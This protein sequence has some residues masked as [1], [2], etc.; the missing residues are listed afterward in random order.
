MHT[1]GSVWSKIDLFTHQKMAILPHTQPRRVHINMKYLIIKSKFDE[2]FVFTWEKKSIKNK[3]FLRTLVPTNSM[4]VSPSS[5]IFFL[6]VG[7]LTDDVKFDKDSPLK[8]RFLEEINSENIVD[9]FYSQN[10]WCKTYL[11]TFLNW[12]LNNP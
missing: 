12:L 7:R 4:P 5:S 8:K 2:V 1:F 6:W 3:R 10:C 11:A 9:T